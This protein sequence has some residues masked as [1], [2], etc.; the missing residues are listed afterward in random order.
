MDD[1]QLGRLLFGGVRDVLAPAHD[2]HM[3]AGRFLHMEPQVL[4][5]GSVEG[6]LIVLGVVPAHQNFKA[7]AGGKAEEVRRLLALIPL[8]VVFQ[9]ALALELG[10]NFIQCRLTG[11]RLH[12]VED[13]FQIG[14]LFFALRQQVHQHPGRRLLLFIILEEVL[15][16]LAGA[17]PQVQRDGNFLALIVPVGHGDVLHPLLGQIEVGGKQLAVEAEL[18]ALAAGG[19][20]F[21]P[22]RLLADRALVHVVHGL[23]QLLAL[24]AE[25]FG[26]VFLGVVALQHGVERG[27]FFDRVPLAVLPGPE[28]RVL[29]RL[30][31]RG[32]HA[33][34]AAALVVELFQLVNG[35]HQPELLGFRQ[36]VGGQ[37][38]AVKG[39]PGRLPADHRAHTGHGL[40]QGV[41]YR[42]IP[43]ASRRHDGSRA[44]REE[45]R[46]GRFRGRGIGQA[47][48][49]LPDIAVLKIH[50]LEGVDDLSILHQHQIGVAAHQLGAED[51][52][53]QVAHLI[54]ALEFKVDDAVA[55]LHPDVQQLAARQVLA[56]QHTERGRRLG[57]LE[58][59]LGQAD[60]GRAAPGRQQQAVGVRAGAQ[61]Q[62]QL[63]AGR[64][65]YFCDLGLG[66]G[67]FQLPGCQ[68]QCRGIQSHSGT[69]LNFSVI[70]A[71]LDDTSPD[72]RG[73]GSP[74]RFP[75]KTKSLCQ[76]LP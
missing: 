47:R 32:R 74:I 15:G 24:G 18:F 14:D 12:L 60:P 40:V 64:F 59:L 61:G 6:E 7:V 34:G 37:V 22:G 19:Q 31:V 67:S 66:Q 20:L 33:A 46:A 2:H 38:L 48:Q 56:H 11:G 3:T 52:P 70:F 75:A 57:V 28:E 73:F 44:H 21:L 16:V 1:R 42:Q 41:C 36:L 43:L 8:L 35:R 13:G 29:H 26:T 25:P 10:T 39:A 9:V 58:A 49:Q 17:E 30:A 23:V 50:P 62:D 65:K 69:S 53:H 71:S 68:G 45:I 27:P 5:S 55:R 4:A 63:I 72:R 54:G 76:G 51:V